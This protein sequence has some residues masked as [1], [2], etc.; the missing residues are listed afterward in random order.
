[1]GGVIGPHIVHLT[2]REGQHGDI[3]HQQDGLA[4]GKGGSEGTLVKLDG[5]GA[6]G[7]SDGIHAY[8]KYNVR[9]HQR[10][11][12]SV[13]TI[14]KTDSEGCEVNRFVVSQVPVYL[15]GLGQNG[16]IIQL[17]RRISQF[18]V[19]VVQRGMKVDVE[20]ASAGGEEI[21]LSVSHISAG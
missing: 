3:H 21:T 6:R 5:G 7:R 16:H 9:K 18:D 13:V 17:Y 15:A 12:V 19:R 2:I 11:S 14:V 4:F 20:V 10:L 1:M 8:I